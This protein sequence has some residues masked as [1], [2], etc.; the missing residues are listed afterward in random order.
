[1]KK[2][3]QVEF[4]KMDAEEQRSINGGYEPIHEGGSIS[5]SASLSASLSAGYTEVDVEV[6]AEG[7]AEW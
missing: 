1:M 6:E 7:E 2:L 4:K 3:S 5:A